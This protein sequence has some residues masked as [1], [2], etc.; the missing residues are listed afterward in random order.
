MMNDQVQELEN[1]VLAYLKKRIPGL[2]E[3]ALPEDVV[4]Q[5]IKMEFSKNSLNTDVSKITDLLEVKI[6]REIQEVETI[7]KTDLS[8]FST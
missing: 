2:Q 6:N 7:E 8:S 1:K 3:G 4:K 5:M